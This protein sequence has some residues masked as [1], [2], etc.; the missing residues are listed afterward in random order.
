M[1]ENDRVPLIELSIQL[2]LVGLPKVPIANMTQK[3]DTFQLKRIERVFR[4]TDRS[5]NVGQRQD[6]K[7]AEAIRMVR[8]HPR[9]VF[10][11]L[12]R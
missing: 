9:G 2:V 11:A 5:F 4:L 8:D 1:N 6:R 3:T 7:P 10:I 12:A